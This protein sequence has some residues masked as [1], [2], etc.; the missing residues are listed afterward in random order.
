MSD[1]LQFRVQ[2]VREAGSLHF[3]GSVDAADF[4]DSVAGYGRM[5]SALAVSTI[6]TK[7]IL[8]NSH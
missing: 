6:K 5:V 3:T 4:Q 1:S 8:T 2:N 7:S